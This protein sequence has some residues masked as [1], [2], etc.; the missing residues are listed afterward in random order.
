M[1][2]RLGELEDSEKKL[3]QVAEEAE[4]QLTSERRMEGSNTW[5]MVLS[6]KPLQ[7]F[8]CFELPKGEDWPGND[9][10]GKDVPLKRSK[11]CRKSML[12]TCGFVVSRLYG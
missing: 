8:H 7:I 11:K 10:K 5:E 12:G 6:K 9:G 3:K 1:L 2:Q 4:E